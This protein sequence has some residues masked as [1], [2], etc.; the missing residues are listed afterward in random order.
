MGS[1][2]RGRIRGDRGASRCQKPGLL[3]PGRMR[4]G[5]RRRE[6]GGS[7]II[8]EV[9]GPSRNPGP[10]SL[11]SPTASLTIS[12]FPLS[13]S[14]SSYLVLLDVAFKT[15]VAAQPTKMLNCF[16]NN[17]N[18]VTMVKSVTMVLDHHSN[19]LTISPFHEVTFSEKTM[20]WDLDF[21]NSVTNKIELCN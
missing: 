3:G 8:R 1:L 11:D 21:L 18:D 12:S 9:G 2:G 16:Q 20:I 15:S 7:S 14:Y 13:I 6:V 19:H 5:R 17:T 4:G 10:S